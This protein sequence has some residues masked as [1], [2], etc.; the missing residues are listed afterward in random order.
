MDNLC[1]GA[2]C[3]NCISC[4]KELASDSLF[5]NFCGTKQARSCPSCG[6]TP[7]PGSL[8]CN[9]C[10]TKLSGEAPAEPKEAKTEPK[11]VVFEEIDDDYDVFADIPILDFTPAEDFGEFCELQKEHYNSRVLAS[12][13]PQCVGYYDKE[14]YSINGDTITICD[15]NG[16]LVSTF[17]TRET[18]DVNRI[19]VNCRGVFLFNYC[20]SGKVGVLAHYSLNGTLL[21]TLPLKGNLINSGYAYG[22]LIWIIQYDDESRQ[23]TLLS[24]DFHAVTYKTHPM[25]WT[26]G[27]TIDTVYG[28]REK[29]IL[30]LSFTG[31]YNNDQG[32]YLFNLK[33]NTITSL[34][35]S[36]LYPEWV[37][38][39]PKRYAVTDETL[40]YRRASLQR[41]RFFDLRKDLMWVA[42][43]GSDG[44]TYL[45]ACSIAPAGQTIPCEDEAVWALGRYEQP[46]YFNG[47][48]MYHSPHYARFGSIAQDG[49]YTDLKEAA[50]GHGRCDHFLVLGDHV[51]IDMDAQYAI[52]QH[53]NSANY[54][55]KGQVMPTLPSMA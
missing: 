44:N 47:K 21:N 39:D 43:D 9:L 42:C 46:D 32:W 3:M 18:P 51:Y 37:L 36:E 34:S 26:K 55:G 41:I 53:P 52:Y 8:F 31:R 23:S 17:S 24:Y 29:A 1:G 45:Q 27:M 13:W 28:T 38:T 54:M 20:I 30:F 11:K 7:G 22:D 25:P 16:E 35:D 50:S 48:V 10:G 15:E 5:C 2:I 40:P 49:A 33:T 12:D 19:F 6:A 4:N 14:I